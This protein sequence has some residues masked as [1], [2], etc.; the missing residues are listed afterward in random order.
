[1]LYARHYTTQCVPDDL[2][3]CSPFPLRYDSYERHPSLAISRRATSLKTKSK[4]RILWM[5]VCRTRPESQ[6]H[7]L[8]WILCKGKK[9]LVVIYLCASLLPPPPHPAM[10]PNSF[11]CTWQ[12]INKKVLSEYDWIFYMPLCFHKI[13]NMP[14]ILLEQDKAQKY[15]FLALCHNYCLKIIRLLVLTN[16]LIIIS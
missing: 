4:A 8:C 7:W 16:V 10:V 6:F 9:E 1:M 15:S 11:S 2:K 3:T 14:C 13:W 12:I 5:T